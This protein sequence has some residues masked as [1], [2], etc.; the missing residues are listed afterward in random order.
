VNADADV[1]LKLLDQMLRYATSLVG[2]D[3]LG[4][5]GVDGRGPNDAASAVV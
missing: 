3:S 1:Y 4:G 5:R 2:S